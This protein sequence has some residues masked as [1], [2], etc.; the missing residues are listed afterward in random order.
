M[1]Q[2][3]DWRGL[4][5][6]AFYV[7]FIAFTISG[8]AAL[9]LIACEGEWSFALSFLF[10]SLPP[11]MI[12]SEFISVALTKFGKAPL[13]VLFWVICSTFI[14]MRLD[15]GEDPMGEPLLLVLTAVLSAAP[16]LITLEDINASPEYASYIWHRIFGYLLITFCALNI[17]LT[18]FVKSQ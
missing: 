8:I 6:K 16:I 7:F 2:C 9:I 17:A 3:V 15:R 11:Y 12:I 18:P 1:T 5:A 4:E 14:S 10:F 13:T